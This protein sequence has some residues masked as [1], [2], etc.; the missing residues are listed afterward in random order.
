MATY[1]KID[2]YEM[3][4]IKENVTQTDNNYSL[5]F[6]LQQQINI[7]KQLDDFVIARQNELNEIKDL[8]KEAEKLGLK[9]KPVDGIVAMEL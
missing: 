4:V 6:L 1:E 5:D 8:I 2:D 7:Q 3:K 9:I